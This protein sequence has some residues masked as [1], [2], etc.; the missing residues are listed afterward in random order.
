MVISHDGFNRAEG[1][2][3]VI[4]VPITTS[5]AQAGRGPTVVKISAGVGGL[6]KS[7]VAV[8]HQITTL[9]RSKLTRRIGALPP[10]VLEDVEAGV[11]T[12]I[13]VE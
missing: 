2:G 3:S 10:D 5:A 1:W 11:K 9:D 7:S 8:C 6:A 12:A 4:V 13:D